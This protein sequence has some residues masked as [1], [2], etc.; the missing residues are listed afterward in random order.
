MERF[1]HQGQGILNAAAVV[2][3]DHPEA[4]MEESVIILPGIDASEALP[5]IIQRFLWIG[6][7]HHQS[8]Q[9]LLFPVRPVKKPA[10]GDLGIRQHHEHMPLVRNTSQRRKGDVGIHEDVVWVE[11]APLV[12]HGSEY[13]MWELFLLLISQ[14]VHPA[15]CP[16]AYEV[17]YKLTA[18]QSVLLQE[19]FEYALA[20]LFD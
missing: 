5:E 10:D 6:F 7:L 1:F 12:R 14:Y 9:E 18:C 16:H 2:P 3:Q 20:L 11:I 17:I 4:G 8:V 13:Q 15:G 19:Q